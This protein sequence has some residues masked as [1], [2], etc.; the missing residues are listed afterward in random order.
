MAAVKITNRMICFILGQGSDKCA[1]LSAGLFITIA[2]IA[3][4]AKEAE[5]FLRCVSSLGTAGIGVMARLAK[6]ANPNLPYA[7]D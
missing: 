6:E 4:T 7:V 3:R 5:R 2:H 1:V